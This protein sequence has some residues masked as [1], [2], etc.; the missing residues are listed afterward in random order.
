[1]NAVYATAGW[2]E[3][4]KDESTVHFINKNISRESIN[5][6]KEQVMSS[7]SRTVMKNPL[8]SSNTDTD[9]ILVTL[10]NPVTNRYLL[11]Q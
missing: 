10:K 5:R 6:V 11:C 7:K 1:M 8:S 3:V 9:R 4:S 2:I